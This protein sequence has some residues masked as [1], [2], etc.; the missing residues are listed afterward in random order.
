LYYARNKNKIENE[1]LIG[2]TQIVK[3]ETNND[4]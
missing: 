2:M 3:F 1:I 4:G